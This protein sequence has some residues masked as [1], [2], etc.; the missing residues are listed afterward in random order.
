MPFC[1]TPSSTTPTRFPWLALG[2]QRMRRKL[3]QV[4]LWRSMALVP[5]CDARV[6]PWPRPLAEA[7]EAAAAW[8]CEIEGSV[9]LQHGPCFRFL[10]HREAEATTAMI[11]LVQAAE[12]A[13]SARR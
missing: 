11:R 9:F 12:R 1:R 2:R 6:S 10:R 8:W 3:C 7:Y 5:Y 13:P 4:G